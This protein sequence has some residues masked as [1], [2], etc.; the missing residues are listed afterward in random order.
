MTIT[1]PAISGRLPTSIPAASAAPDEIPTGRPSTR[2]LS[3]AISIAVVLEMRTTSS[4]SPVLR[5]GGMKPA[6]IP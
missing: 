5:I 3:R 4:I 2:A 6:P 1:L